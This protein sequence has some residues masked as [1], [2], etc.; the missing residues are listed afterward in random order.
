MRGRG[1]GKGPKVDGSFLHGFTNLTRSLVHFFFSF[2]PFIS[3][4]WGKGGRG[5]WTGLRLG[6]DGA[7]QLLTVSPEIMDLGG[8]GNLSRFSVHSL[9][10][11][12]LESV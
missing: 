1:G 2:F 12:C 7:H 5:R 4:R 3:A 9:A 8:S 6:K 10:I 11:S